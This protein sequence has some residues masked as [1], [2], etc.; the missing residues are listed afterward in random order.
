MDHTF[1]RDF[2]PHGHCYFWEPGIVWTHA[3]SDSIIALAYFIIPF[4]LVHIVRK[5]RDFKYIWMGVLFAVFILGCGTTHVF[6]VINIWKPYYVA[7]ASIR[8]I[9]ALASIGTAI[10]LVKITPKILVIPSTEKWKQVNE[11]LL[12]NQESLLKSNEEL[13]KTEQI[14]K[15]LNAD[16]ENRV[17]QRTE[18]SLKKAEEFEFLSD[19]IPQLVWTTDADGQFEYLN[20]RWLQYTGQSLEK[21]K[22]SGW[23]EAIHPDH[24]EYAIEK[25]RTCVQE[26][27]EFQ[28]EFCLR[29]ASGA[30]RWF[31]A[32]GIPM[33][34]KNGK[35]TKW[36]GTC[37]DIHDQKVQAKEL[38][39][40]NIDLKRINNDLDNFIYTASHDLRAPISNMEGLLNTI[41]GEAKD[42]CSTEVNTLFMMLNT[43][44]AR[45]KTTI[46]DLTDISRVQ[47]NV[48]KDLTTIDISEV[49][50]EF[51]EN[52]KDQI[53]THS[54]VIQ[55]NLA[56]NF[57][58]FSKK[59]FR[60]VFYNLVNNAIKYH[61]PDRNPEITIS[62]GKEGNYIT[63]TIADNGIGFDNSQRDKL[64]GMFKRLHSHV[65]GSGIGL[66]IVKRIMENSNGKVEVDSE[67][68]KGSTF[69][70]YFPILGIEEEGK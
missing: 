46:D 69:K 7:D 64:F 11:E 6:D 54:A 44:V 59:N 5:R 12:T 9:T 13:S 31:L 47:K 18:E 65:E 22:G 24:V 34:N 30:Y 60:S 63:L 3:V 50:E 4:M 57:V 49:L 61:H 14:L 10:M 15:D 67:V 43:S 32:K 28:T 2:M 55:A 70:L 1:H 52:H 53:A 39:A 45:L 23:S 37:T 17:K 51:K 68:G 29:N 40:A 36:F 58:A 35:V 19:T 38:E 33:K 56:E 42:V 25:W 48:N 20:K 66:Y 62:T 27:V 41:Y 26:E 21:A 8:V 16:L